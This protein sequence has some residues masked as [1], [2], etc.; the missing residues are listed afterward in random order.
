MKE[1]QVGKK[2]KV[3]DVAG[4]VIK[5]EKITKR[6]ITISGDYTGRFYKYRSNF[7]R[8]GEDIE[9]PVGKFTVFCFA[10]HEVN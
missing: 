3:N 6:Y 1:F 2:Y 10:G 4:S 9:I 5:V 7:F 8:L